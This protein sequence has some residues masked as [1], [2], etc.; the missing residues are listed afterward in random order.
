MSSKLRVLGYV[1]VY[2]QLE[3]QEELTTKYQSRCTNVG[4]SVH[5]VLT[6]RMRT[7]GWYPGLWDKVYPHEPPPHLLRLHSH[8]WTGAPHHG[9]GGGSRGWGSG[10][11][12][13][14]FCGCF[15]SNMVYTVWFGINILGMLP[16]PHQSWQACLFCLCWFYISVK[17][18]F[19]NFVNFT[20]LCCSLTLFA[21]PFLAIR[22]D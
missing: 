20:I 21:V 8:T 3:V 1:C 2:A 14:Q 12:W 11:G 5:W 13:V 7:A 4:V 19:N 10:G 18:G 17:S 9:G 22:W 6:W 15:P 16:F